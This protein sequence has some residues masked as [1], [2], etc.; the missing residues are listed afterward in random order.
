MGNGVPAGQAA[1]GGSRPAA[2][3]AGTG[4]LAGTAPR[5]DPERGQAWHAGVRTTY[6]H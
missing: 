4:I 1:R 3:A 2:Q 5:T 6:C